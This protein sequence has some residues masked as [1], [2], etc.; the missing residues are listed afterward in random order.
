MHLDGLL[1]IHY[2]ALLA[3]L[4]EVAAVHRQVEQHEE[5][6]GHHAPGGCPPQEPAAGAED[7]RQGS[8][9]DL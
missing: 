5:Y 4:Y 1:P 7:G 6:D 8:D 3:P 2:S 9:V